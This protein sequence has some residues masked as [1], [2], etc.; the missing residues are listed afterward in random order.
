MYSFWGLKLTY[1]LQTKKKNHARL[2]IRLPHNSIRSHYIIMIHTVQ[3]N[4]FLPS[5]Y[6]ENLCINHW[7]Y[8]YMYMYIC[9]I[10]AW[11]WTPSYCMTKPNFS[12]LISCIYKPGIHAPMPDAS[13]SKQTGARWLLEVCGEHVKK[14]M[15]TMCLTQMSWLPWSHRHWTWTGPQP[16]FQVDIQCRQLWQ[17]LEEQ[18]NV[19]LFFIKYKLFQ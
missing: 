13:L 11:A 6:C 9:L 15:W 4:I 10:I 5:V 18:G 8:M 12:S 19:V 14:H 3:D 1:F 17:D 16:G 7:M 2:N